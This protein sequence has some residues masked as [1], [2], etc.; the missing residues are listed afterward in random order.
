MTYL[1]NLTW[2][3]RKPKRQVVHVKDDCYSARTFCNTP[4]CHGPFDTL[5]EAVEWARTTGYPV[6]LCHFCDF[7]S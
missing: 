3:S 2:D 7:S 6:K 1:V 4:R 5:E